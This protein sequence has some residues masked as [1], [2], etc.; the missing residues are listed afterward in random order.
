M[1]ISVNN[2]PYFAWGDDCHGWWLKKNGDFTVI[3]ESMPKDTSEIAHFHEYSEQFFY[4]IEGELVIEV[5]TV[6]HRLKKQESIIIAP[7]MVHRVFNDSDCI[8]KFLVVSCP[9]SH[10]DRV[11]I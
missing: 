1:K 8:V 5:E 6:Q 10:Q 9:D 7:K 4:V 2:A 11:N 3:F